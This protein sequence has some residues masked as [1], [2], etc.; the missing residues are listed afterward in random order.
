MV[1]TDSDPQVIFG[2]DYALTNSLGVFGMIRGGFYGGGSDAGTFAQN[3]AVPL[4]LR[5]TGVG[6]RCVQDLAL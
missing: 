6:F 2:E 5:T 4:D 1:E 3:L